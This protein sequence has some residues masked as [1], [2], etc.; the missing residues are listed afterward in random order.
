M[1]SLPGQV[2][3]FIDFV[4][5]L[6]L[7]AQQQPDTLALSF[8][9]DGDQVTDTRTYAQLHQHCAANAATFLNVANAGDRVLILLDSSPAY[10]ESFL[11]CLYAGLVAVPA[12]PPESHSQHHLARLH[13]MLQDCQ[14]AVVVISAAHQALFESIAE[15]SP[16]LTLP[17]I[18]VI[19]SVNVRDSENWKKTARLPDDLAF[20]QY[21]S[22]STSAPKGVMVSHKNLYANEAVMQE[23]FSLTSQSVI[24]NWLPLFHDMGLM[25]GALLPLFAGCPL[26]LMSPKHFLERPVRWLR[27]VSDFG[28]TLSGGPDF[29]YRLCAERIRPAQMKGIDLSGWQNAFS[30]SEPVRIDTL[31]SF[32]ARF[33]DY[34][35]QH[36]SL[37]PA[38]GQA[39]TTLYVTSCD[40][41]KDMLVVDFAANAMAEGNAVP[42]T[43][44]QRD[45]GQARTTLVGCGRTR[46]GHR[47]GIF[48]SEIN[49]ELPDDVVGEIC[50]CGDSNTQGY[51]QNPEATD[52]LF[53]WQG[54]KQYLR[55]GDLGFMHQGQLFITGRKKDLIIIRGQNHYP[56]DIELTIEEQVDAVR[57]GRVSA[58]ALNNDGEETLAIA[59]EVSRSVQKKVPPATLFDSIRIAIADA[60]QLSA[61]VIVLLQPKGLPK[62]TSGKLQRSACQLAWENDGFDSY[63][64]FDHGSIW[65][66]E[67]EHQAST[68]PP[69]D[70]AFS[71]EEQSLADLWQAVLSRKYP[72]FD[73][74][75]IH[76]DSHF[77]ALGGDSLLAVQLLALIKE[78]WQKTLT[79]E[80]IFQHPR[81]GEMSQQVGKIAPDA[82]RSPESGQT[83]QKPTGEERSTSRFPLSSAQRG[84]YFLSQ[85]DQDKASYNVPIAL[86]LNGPLHTTALEQALN[87]LIQRHSSLRTGFVCDDTGALQQRVTPTASLSLRHAT[88]T[89][90][91]D[92]EALGKRESHHMFHLEQGPLIRALLVTEQTDRQTLF[93]TLHHIITDGWSIQILLRELRDTYTNLTTGQ[94]IDSG[95]TAISSTFSDY[96]WQQQQW[97]DSAETAPQLS[98][99]KTQLSPNIPPLKLGFSRPRPPHISAAGERF[100]FRLDDTLRDGLMNLATQEDATLFMVILTAFQLQLHKLS[101]ERDI[102]IGV[103]NANRGT[104]E[105]M[106]VTGFFVNTQVV[107]ADVREDRS[108]RSLLAQNKSTLFAAQQ[109]SDV[110]FDRVIDTLQ[111]QRDLSANPLFQIKCTQQLDLSDIQLADTIATDIR[112]VDD[113][114][115]HFDLG[116]DITDKQS[117]IDCVVTYSTDLFDARRITELA[118]QFVDVCAQVVRDTGTGLVANYRT[119][120]TR[121]PVSTTNTPFTSVLDRWQHQVTQQPNATAVVD[122]QGEYSTRH[123]DDL[124]N[125][126]AHQLLAQGVQPGEIVSLELERGAR[127]IVGLL[128]CF[129][130]GAVYLP[131]DRTLPVARRDH[132]TR[133]AECRVRLH[134][135]TIDLSTPEPV[136]APQAAA[137]IAPQHGA[138]LVFTSGSTGTP[139]GVEISHGALAHYVGAIHARMALKD[140][141]RLAS[142]SGISADLGNTLLFEA[143]CFGHCLHTIPDAVARDPDALAD[144]RHQQRIDGLKITPSYLQGL[145]AAEHPAQ[146]LP[147]QLLILGGESCS[148]GFVRRLQ[149]LKPSVRLMNHYGPTETT[150]GAISCDL[151]DWLQGCLASDDTPVPLGQPLPGYTVQLLTADNTEVA[152]GQTGELVIA[153]PALATGYLGQPE[154]T[155]TCFPQIHH[156]RVYRSGDR[157]YQD[158]QGLLVFAGRQDDQVKVRGYRVELDD[159]RRALESLEHVTQAHVMLTSGQPAQL[160]A[161]CCLHPQ[162][163]EARVKQQL[164]AQVPDYMVPSIWVSVTDMPLLPSGKV[165][166]QTLSGWLTRPPGTASS[167]TPTTDASTA[168]ESGTPSLA[169][170]LLGIWGEVLGKDNLTTQ[171]NFFDVGGDSILSLQII[172]RARKQGIKLVPKQLFQHQTID[173]LIAAPGVARNAPATENTPNVSQQPDTTQ[174]L[175]GIWC[176]VLGNAH[177]TPDD[178]F[179]DVGGDSILSLQIIARARKQGI[180]LMPKQLFQHQTVRSLVTMLSASTPTHGVNAAVQPAASVDA[181]NNNVPLSP[182]QQRFFQHPVNNRNHWN[183]SIRLELTGVTTPTDA[184]FLSLQQGLADVIQRHPILSAQYRPATSVTTQA[185]A[186]DWQ[187]IVPAVRPNVTVCQMLESDLEDDILAAANALQRSLN[188]QTGELLKA[189]L[190][191]G[192]PACHTHHQ[193]I[194]L[195]LIA[196]HLV[197][198]GVSWRVLLHELQ[199]HLNGQPVRSEPESGFAQWSRALHQLEGATPWLERARIHWHTVQQHAPNTRL[200]RLDAAS[201]TPATTPLARL[202]RQQAMTPSVCRNEYLLTALAHTLC[203]VPSHTIST[204]LIDVEGHGRTPLDTGSADQADVS[205]SIGWFTAIYPWQL[206]RGHDVSDSLAL[207]QRQQHDVREI[208]DQSHGVLRYTLEDAE[209][210]TPVDVLFN[211]LGQFDQQSAPA[212]GINLVMSDHASGVMRDPDTRP[213]H[214]LVINCYHRQG[215]LLCEW[216]YQ[217][218]LL[219]PTQV[220]QWADR[221][222]LQLTA[223]QTHQA[224]ERVAPGSEPGA[225]PENR[226]AA[227]ANNT[228]LQA[229]DTPLADLTQAELERIPDYQQL[230]DVYPLS[231]LQQGMLFH[232]VYQQDT[233]STSATQAYVNQL[234]IDFTRLDT[235]RFQRCWEQLVNRHDVLRTGFYFEDFTRTPLQCVYRQATPVIRVLD[236]RQHQPDHAQWQALLD[237]ERGKNMLGMQAP[238]MRF[239]LVRLDDDT[240]RCL[241]TR[242]H[243]LMDG[244]SSANLFAQFLALYQG[245]PSEH[246]DPTHIGHYR[247][248]IA[249]LQQQATD[250][251]QAFWTQQLATVT[252]PTRLSAYLPAPPNTAQAS[253]RA[254]GTRHITINLPTTV[255]RQ[256]KHNARQMRVTMNT[257]MQAGWAIL[258]HNYTRQPEVVMGVTVAGRPVDIP[259]LHQTIGLFINTLP[260]NINM[261]KNDSLRDWLDRLQQTNL[262]IR[263]YEHSALFDI[264]RWAPGLEPMSDQHSNALFDTLLVFENYPVA[265]SLQTASNGLSFR[266]HDNQEPTNYALTVV[267]QEALNLGHP[268]QTDAPNTQLR[269]SFDSHQ[270]E[271]S[272]IQSLARQYQRILQQLSHCDADARV[273]SGMS[274]LADLAQVLAFSQG[275]DTRHSLAPP[276]SA[277]TDTAAHTVIERIARQAEQTPHAI[278]LEY[279]TQSLSYQKMITTVNQLA[280]RLIEQGVTPDDLVGLCSERSLEM[281]IGLLAIHR[282]GAAYVPLDPDHPNER[283]AYILETAQSPL[284]LT[285]H[286]LADRL[287][288]V[289]ETAGINT[290]I[291]DLDNEPLNPQ[292]EHP[293]AVT[294]HPQ[295]LAYVIFT[296]GSTGNPKGAANSHEALLNRLVWMQQAYSLTDQDCVLQKTPFG[297]DVSVWEFFWPLMTG[298]RL[299]IAP[300][301]AH[302]HPQQLMAL[303]DQ[304][305][306]TTLHFVPSMLNAFVNWKQEV[307]SDH[308]QSTLRQM[309]CSGEALP[310]ELQ[311][312]TLALWPH[313]ALYN[314]YGPTEAAID[315]THWHCQPR[316]HGQVP[317]GKPIA[318]TR[319]YLLDD[320]LNPVPCGVAG[321]LYIAGINLAR[322][323][324]QRPGLTADRFVPDPFATD[325]AR[326]YRSGDLASWHPDG[327]IEYLGRLDHQVKLRG[328]RIELEEIEAAIVQHTPIAQAAVAVQSVSGSEQLIAYLVHTENHALASDTESAS[329]N[330]AA[331][332][333]PESIQTALAQRL[334]GYMVPALSVTLPE[335]PQTTSG[336]LDRKALP[337]PE[338]TSSTVT[339]EAPASE[340]EQQLAHFWS[341][342]LGLHVMGTDTPPEHVA[343]IGRHSNFFGLGGHS[344]LVVKVIARIQQQLNL[345]CSVAEFFAANTLADLA[346]HLSSEPSTLFDDSEQQQMDSLLAELEDL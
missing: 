38:Y 288:T 174:V 71:P 281:V 117:G 27:A 271:P 306:V 227:P 28:A 106:D 275:P 184:V 15:Q 52:N 109:H 97:L 105:R 56:Q 210:N 124:S 338:L 165:D 42:L 1:N 39:E 209:L 98:Y 4:D 274:D 17:H 26:V 223:L 188:I 69:K 190:V 60:H 177:L 134:P 258:L 65:N 215:K 46:T 320:D 12:Y 95:L 113:F 321:E 185:L 96:V 36:V 176:D 283:L 331:C 290:R 116:L 279:G 305:R 194:E 169:Q 159:V 235:E 316:Q 251:A 250:S 282:A 182:M 143:L 41:E 302:R 118:A 304:H 156:Q 218:A 232:C 195:I 50:P 45:A 296:S 48:H 207:S 20:L 166:R 233:A 136:S 164:S 245:H 292:H 151:S 310:T 171:D 62:T 172:A 308:Q 89:A 272:T 241:W 80:H 326:M 35:F 133:I 197:I 24:V 18:L 201:H 64:L 44:E 30:G 37:V 120:L 311:N 202:H 49:Q 100:N 83:R 150:V 229:A 301:D 22:G 261:E 135:D 325:G 57:K 111:P 87:H 154:H 225:T 63:A 341:E 125:R 51:W 144:Y 131:L 187:Q 34:G 257:M 203:S 323:Y 29:A 269:F 191:V 119:A 53:F 146:M 40:T 82:P 161:F 142:V 267:V 224:T 314:L 329:S 138:Y 152:P 123:M 10:I 260:V 234:Q 214:A 70:T 167:A 6:C 121:E 198:D 129:K 68:Q 11:G 155:A 253:N 219:D 92:L 16:N 75:G 334:P 247:H 127:F 238:L 141:S 336:K 3:A 162:A 108:F 14:P 54:G 239:A 291:L 208:Q 47:V 266:L 73:P 243:I 313:V 237:D 139:K 178:N 231:P 319:I 307:E 128:A 126:L 217:T 289:V 285:S 332:P 170:T 246:D 205:N 2:S 58:F 130:V 110:P 193:P 101:G 264:Q 315:V 345:S 122:E 86:S 88:A 276:H 23:G 180:T 107:R 163:T 242:H 19:E 33:A 318:N 149:A 112:W 91:S 249:W 263:D 148:T 21:T 59:A 213:E 181:T 145:L 300:P 204:L 99:W 222:L 189:L 252:E 221:F 248:Y 287:Q 328:L 346:D 240:I 344:L 76:R 236:W 273:P 55:S 200:P 337:Q 284:I 66:A 317:I 102:R 277:P 312:T 303:I 114:A 278:A 140:R 43:A 309:V 93:L 168:L 342:V 286:P 280:H 8:L 104:V 228:A 298:A 256:L 67:S 175:L 295:Q 132:I 115:A 192:S 254:N 81:L 94:P 294:I 157:A 137:V 77:F 327:A 90:P 25:S 199:R 244:W 5:L 74:S 211:Y 147:D 84:L 32:E 179:F 259:E 31:R 61:D 333:L 212:E 220:A 297:F 7:R 268:G 13:S 270:F 72:Q 103:P 79:A 78:R 293:P 324:H 265:A 255:S 196:H 226:T 230:Q 186:R 183:Q 339:N 206:Q 262:A 158:P 160:A 330:P 216:Q 322:G 299:A 335:L 153:G 173:A 85:L 9:G 340:L 343:L